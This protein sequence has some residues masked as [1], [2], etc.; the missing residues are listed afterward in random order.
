MKEFNEYSV[1]EGYTDTEKQPL[2]IRK[3]FELKENV[4]NQN[5]WDAATKEY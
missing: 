1:T 4:M 2:G 3:Y 5:L